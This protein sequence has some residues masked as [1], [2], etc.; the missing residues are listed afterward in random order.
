MRTKR[1]LLGV[2]WVVLSAVMSYGQGL[3]LVWDNITARGALNG[4]NLARSIA[5]AHERVI[6]GDILAQADSFDTDVRIEA[7]DAANGNVLWADEVQNASDVRVLAENGNVFAY[8]W[9]FAGPDAPNLILIRYSLRTG[10]RLWSTRVRLY[11]LQQIILSHGRLIVV[12]YDSKPDPQLGFVLFGSIVVVDALHGNLL[13]Q[14]AIATADPETTL[15]DV[16]EAGR[17]IVMVGFTDART[18]RPR[19]TVIASYRLVTGH[20]DWQV[21]EPEGL[22]SSMVISNGVA[23]IAGNFLAAYALTDGHRLW[24]ALAGTSGLASIRYLDI[25]PAGLYV[26][27]NRADG[28]GPALLAR[29]DPATGETLW[30]KTEFF[31]NDFGQ[32]LRVD[33]KLVAVGSLPE[34]QNFPSIPRRL[35]VQVYGF[36]GTLEDE[37]LYPLGTRARDAATDG[38]RLAIAGS[39]SNAGALIQ[40]YELSG[41][42]P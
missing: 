13:W 22:L 29:I 28:N 23:Y 39:R 6:A 38:H 31:N 12:G 18:L 25:S 24:K 17:N 19:Q 7:R 1:L 34:S 11:N 36:D 10:E 4:L 41:I 16:D 42:Q 26:S 33:N 37:I 9:Q 2:I 20:L 40:V 3:E 8:V 14:K 35:R 5:M 27:G 32:V 15:W 30:Q 21:I